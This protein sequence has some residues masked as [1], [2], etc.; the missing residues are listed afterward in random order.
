M[1]P[2]EGED[3]NENGPESVFSDNITVPSLNQG[4]QTATTTNPLA[5]VPSDS[6]A[7]IPHHGVQ[8]S[9]ISGTV[10]IPT[11]PALIAS[12]SPSVLNP[13]ISSIISRTATAP[14]DL[15]LIASPSPSEI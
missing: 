8:G 7:M 13:D 5:F 4:G 3:Q 11:N 10:T 9:M 6:E 1:D 15:A 14:T 12:P 2:I